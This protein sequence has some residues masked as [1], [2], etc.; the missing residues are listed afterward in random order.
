MA[1]NFVGSNNINLLEPNGQFGTRL[2]GGKMQVAPRYIW[3]KLNKLTK[4]IFVPDDNPLLKYNLDDGQKVEPEWYIPII[5][6]VL[7][8]GTEGIGTG[9]STKVPSHN[10]LDII[11]NI[12]NILDGNKYS[13]MKPWFKNFTGK[14]KI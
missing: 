6:L 9:F 12:N 3:T 5:P 8:N 2:Q 1:Q 4:L 11:S 7:V 13:P 10:P 14:G